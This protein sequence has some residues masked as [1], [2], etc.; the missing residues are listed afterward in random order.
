[1]DK[2]EYRDRLLKISEEDSFKLPREEWYDRIR[3]IREIIGMEAVKNNR[4]M[5]QEAKIDKII[6]PKPR[7]KGLRV[8]KDWVND[9]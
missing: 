9:L 1:M 7:N 4:A 8:V 3:F 6:E 2:K 5:M